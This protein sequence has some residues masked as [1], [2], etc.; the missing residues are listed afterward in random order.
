M[1][2]EKMAQQAR[3]YAKEVT[4]YSINLDRIN[5]SINERNRKTE[6]KTKE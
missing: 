6:N 3:A 1:A 4:R 2:K 5:L